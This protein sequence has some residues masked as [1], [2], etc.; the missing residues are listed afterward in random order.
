M[1]LYQDLILLLSLSRIKF[2][3]DSGKSFSLPFLVLEQG[4]LRQEE[5]ETNISASE[6]I[7]GGG[8]VASEDRDIVS[9]GK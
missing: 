4:N 2:N 5:F 7:S 6:S 3:S 1:F 8:Q 9:G